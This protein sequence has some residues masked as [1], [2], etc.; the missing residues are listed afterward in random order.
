MIKSIVLIVSVLICF[1]LIYIGLQ[2]YKKIKRRTYINLKK[3]QEYPLVF[4]KS[5]IKNHRL[6]GHSA[7]I[8]LNNFTDSDGKRL[9][10]KDYRGFIVYGNGYNDVGIYH[11]D[12]VFMK[13]SVD[14]MDIKH[15]D[16]IIL[17]DNDESYVIRQFLRYIG[18]GVEVLNCN[19]ETELFDST[20][21]IVGKVDY[22]FE[23]KL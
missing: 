18:S 8:D 1:A 16:F 22:D 2:E 11:D 15:Y 5:R 20:E 19:E 3:E 13:N 14:L 17:R 23:I 10:S 9:G 7:S 4:T 21:R 6:T 12:L